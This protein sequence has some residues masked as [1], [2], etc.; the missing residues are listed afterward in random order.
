MNGIE[1]QKESA[2]PIASFQPLDIVATSTTNDLPKPVQPRKSNIVKLNVGGTH[3]ITTQA[4]ANKSG[5]LRGLLSG[6]FG[7]DLDDQGRYF[8]DRKGKYFEY[9]LDYMRSGYV[10]IPLQFAQNIKIE[11]EYFI[12]DDFRLVVPNRKPITVTIR[13]TVFGGFTINGISCKDIGFT[14]A[15]KNIPGVEKISRNP[16]SGY[17]SNYCLPNGTTILSVS[18][19][20]FHL[21]GEY[22]YK[23]VFKDETGKQSRY[24]LRKEPPSSIVVSN[25]HLNLG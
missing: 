10:E 12:I 23:M 19:L 20:A 24:V 15:M 6:K 17:N 2:G 7:V 16:K 11:S 13:N 25:S 5:Y 22:D 4:T 18:D 8:I 1:E 21:I 9:L 3:F 14:E